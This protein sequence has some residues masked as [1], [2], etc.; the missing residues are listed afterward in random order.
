MEF[1]RL[2][3]R[4]LQ[5]AGYAVT[6]LD[7]ESIGSRSS[8]GNTGFWV[9]NPWLVVN[10]PGLW[11]SLA[12]ISRNRDPR[13]RVDW[14]FVSSRL[15][16]FAAFLARTSTRHADAV[17]HSLRSLL[18]VSQHQ[19]KRWIATAGADGL[20]RRTGWLKVFRTDRKSTRLNSSH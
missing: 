12:R 10:N 8:Y 13:V 1:R 2:L 5:E 3:F 15:P 9:E 18:V 11:K 6:L 7:P 14:R 20:L 17:A 16:L 19:H 4:S